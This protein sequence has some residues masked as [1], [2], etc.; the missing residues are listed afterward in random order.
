MDRARLL[1]L[2]YG[3]LCREVLAREAAVFAWPGVFR[4]LRRM[5]LSGEVVSGEFFAGLS[6]PQFASPRAVRLF[7]EGLDGDES[8]WCAGRDPVAVWSAG[9]TDDGVAL[10]RRAAGCAAAFI[11]ARAVLAVQAGGGRIDTVLSPDD[12]RLPA[13]LAPLQNALCR[14]VLPEPRLT[15]A[16]INGDPAGESPYLP[17]LRQCFEVVRERRGVTLF[18]A[19][20]DV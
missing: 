20:G 15:V 2:R 12:A 18:R 16:T 11:G 4:A 19:R 5:E 9:P 7:T 3:V 14:R 1:L 6:G 17:L 8:W 10:P 13:A